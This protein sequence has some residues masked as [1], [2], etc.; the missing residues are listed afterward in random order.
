MKVSRRVSAR[1]MRHRT[2]CCCCII[3]V[4]IIFRVCRSAGLEV[5][6]RIERLRGAETGL[7]VR[8]DVLDEGEG[9]GD[10]PLVL[11]GPVHDRGAQ[12][13]RPRGG[14]PDRGQGWEG[15]WQDAGGRGVERF[16][17]WR[18]VVFVADCECG[19]GGGFGA[20][21]DRRSE[22]LQVCEAGHEFG[23]FHDAVDLAEAAEEE[24]FDNVGVGGGVAVPA[25]QAALDAAGVG[26]GPELLAEGGDHDFE[27]LVGREEVC[28]GVLGD[29]AALQVFTPGADL[30]D[31]LLWEPDRMLSACH[32]SGHG[33]E[34]L[35]AERLEEVADYEG[36]SLQSFHHALADR[37]EL[38]LAGCGLDLVDLVLNE[39]CHCDDHLVRYSLTVEHLEKVV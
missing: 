33:F 26:W 15:D 39:V 32:F 37:C 38:A 8:D 16:H 34:D 31:V 23:A 20:G 36:G 12:D 19:G 6:I 11:D 9:V 14:E 29:D 10:G 17:G 7:A 22:A 24:D 13:A 28:F 3:L 1:D 25:A 18:S 5:D 27:E 35:S 30:A 2:C 21:G 4:T